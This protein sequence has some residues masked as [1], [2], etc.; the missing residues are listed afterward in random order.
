MASSLAIKL[1]KLVWLS[2]EDVQILDGLS[3]NAKRHGSKSDLIKEG[4]PPASVFLITEGWACRYKI[5]RNGKRQISAI[6][7][8]GDLSDVHMF[9]PKRLDH[10]IGLLGDGMVATIP[11]QKVLDI[12]A[13]RPA[14]A[15]ALCRVTLADQS[16]LREWLINVGQR[17]A[18]NRVAHLLA[19]LC[20]RLTAVDQTVD[21]TFK[22]PV[23]QA[24]LGD[25]LGLTAVHI[26]RTIQLLRAEGLIEI[27][28]G[29]LK[30]PSIERLMAASQFDAN[31]L[32]LSS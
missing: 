30:I 6:L 4:D 31:Y 3:D 2:D 20:L 18:R 9:S 27:T 24:D 5:L 14:I 21:Y 13:Q 1:S 15:E 22:L 32:H 17:D 8:P 29:C 25:M 11:K 10:S 7:L 16:V 12:L 23:T 26:N 19:E 28:H